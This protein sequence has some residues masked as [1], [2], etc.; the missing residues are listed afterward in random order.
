VETFDPGALIDGKFTIVRRLGEGGMGLVLAASRPGL[1]SLVAVKVLLPRLRDNPEVCAR[2][3]REAHAADALHNQHITRIHDVGTTPAGT[4]YI[5]MEYLDGEN[6]AAAIKKR[7]PFSVPDA[8]DLLLQTCEAMAEAHAHAI[9]HRDLKPGNLFV[10]E[11]HGAPFVK[12]LDFGIAKASAPDDLVKTDTAAFFGSPLY[13]SPEQLLRPKAVDARTDVWALGIILYEMLAGVTPFTGETVLGLSTAIAAGHFPK[14]STVREGIPPELDALLAEALATSLESRLPSVEAFARKLA[15]F[16]GSGA[17]QSYEQ[18]ARIAGTAK[19]PEPTRDTAA[20][21]LLEKTG[22]PFT[23]SIAPASKTDQEVEDRPAATTEKEVPKPEAPP[24]SQRA[25]ATKL[26]ALMGVGLVGTAIAASVVGFHPT[27]TEGPTTTTSSSTP[28]SAAVPSASAAIA[29]SASPSAE[30]PPAAS[31]APSASAPVVALADPVATGSA[32]AKTGNECAKGATRACEAACTAHAPGRCEA[33]ARALVKGTGAPKDVARAVKLYQDEC[34]AGSGSACNALG[35]LY[36]LGTDVTKDNAKAV[37]LYKHG[38]DHGDR[39]ACVNLGGMHFSG[40][41]LA[42]NQELGVSYFVRGCP[43]SGPVE[44]LGCVNLSVAYSKGLG[45]PKDA[46]QALAYAKQGCDSG[47]PRGCT[48]ASMAKVTGEGVP[49]DVR[50]G[51]AELDAQC[52]RGEPSA[53]SELLLIYSAG[54]GTDVQPNRAQAVAIAAKGCA[55]HDTRS[56][57]M[58]KI[59][60]SQDSVDTALSQSRAQ[61]ETSCTAGVQRDCGFLGELLL[62]ENGAADH[63]RGLALLGA[64]C[65]RGVA[66]ACRMLPDAGR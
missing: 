17:R 58:Q 2:F 24:P 29:P 45:V 15:P 44:P 49:K 33:L 8:A 20:V 48:L 3:T 39:T 30:P 66:R 46:A 28:V 25:S 52:G 36:A 50:G 38:C 34:D 47:A 59:F 18:V 63:A 23:D 62:K 14:L 40:T 37:T 55:A 60:A 16:G 64:A 12:V 27:H 26:P 42:K 56:C 53:C 21:A 6:L 1:S 11:R 61:L 41:G 9:I 32:P 10:L 57:G 35:N 43:S 22:S 5:V 19:G 13:M 31:S 65:T 54:L 51:L 4:P 7:G